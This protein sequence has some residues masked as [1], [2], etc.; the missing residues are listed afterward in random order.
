MVA[1]DN[2]AQVPKA[3]APSRRVGPVCLPLM[4]QA[5]TYFGASGNF[6]LQWIKSGPSA[7]FESLQKLEYGYDPVGNILSIQD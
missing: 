5:R 6:R 7:P 3:T 2:P 1:G 4:L